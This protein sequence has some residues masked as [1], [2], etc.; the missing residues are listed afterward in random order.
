MSKIGRPK[1][2]VSEKVLQD[3]INQYLSEF[4]T[5]LQIKYKN[6]FEYARNIEVQGESYWPPSY[7]FWRREGRRGREV[8]DEV[9]LKLATVK[10]SEPKEYVVVSTKDTFEEYKENINKNKDKIIS[11]L[12]I[13]EFNLVQLIS[14]HQNLANKYR[15][16]LDKNEILEKRLKELE[17]RN[18]E[19][20]TSFFQIMDI[21]DSKELNM[22]T[23]LITTDMNR[24]KLVSD[25]FSEM[26]S[27]PNRPYHNKEGS[28]NN[29]VVSFN[30][31]KKNSMIED[32]NL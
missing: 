12:K 3:V 7:E 17:S 8:V 14:K 18:K 2:N 22:L 32:L 23:D 25:L 9:N 19:L 5:I 28:K 11:K 24:S 10:T 26:F 13:N 29:N 15:V 6:I 1:E 20:E 4:P 16:S 30:R 21:S 31:N 27:N